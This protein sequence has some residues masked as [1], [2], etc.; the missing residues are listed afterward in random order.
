VPWFPCPVT[1]GVQVGAD[2]LKYRTLVWRASG[3]IY[4]I[5]FARKRGGPA[6]K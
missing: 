4:H 6:V 5:L 2:I 1:V 3:E